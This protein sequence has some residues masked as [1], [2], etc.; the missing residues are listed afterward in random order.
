MGAVPDDGA[1][2]SNEGT[3]AGEVVEADGVGA[4]HVFALVGYFHAVLLKSL[5]RGE[6]VCLG[7]GGA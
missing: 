2:A 5:I 6:E 7:H 1:H 3:G 4:V